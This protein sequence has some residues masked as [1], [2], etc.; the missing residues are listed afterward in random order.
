LT[1]PLAAFG[2]AADDLSGHFDA[3]AYPEQV[4]GRVAHIDA[5]F[6]AYQ[7]SAE[8]KDELDGIKPRRTLSDMQEGAELVAT[9]L[10]RLCGASSYVCHVTPSGSN[11]GSRPAQAVQQE[12]QANRADKEK[13]EH[14]DAV[15]AYIG[16]VLNG[17]V[18]LEREADDGMAIANYSAV[19]RNLS[20]IVSRDKDLRMVPG[21]HWCFDTEALVD[22]V[23]TFGSIWVD[24][25]K[26]SKTLKGWGTKFFWAQCLMGDT[27][28][29]IKGL[30]AVPGVV[31]CELQPTQTYLKAQEQVRKAPT[32]EYMTGP[33]K[34]MAA[35]RAKTKPCGVVMAY[36]LLADVHNDSDAFDLVRRLFVMLHAEHYHPF[37][38]WQT[39]TPVTPTQALLGD[40]QLLW[41][42]RSDD[43][44]DVVKWLKEVRS[45]TA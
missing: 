12:Y 39:G 35:A 15:R 11:K 16:T 31:H 24:D 27:A 21:L 38:H 37:E 40:M 10:M 33:M 14:L 18:H 30:P 34:I 6:L 19:D 28:D 41:M 25:S 22:V 7:V 9:G 43:P 1:N 45:G 44:L 4:P 20:V 23:D 26:S 42:R 5:D 3:V 32:P 13:P 2:V 36:N 29:H 17:V 8:T